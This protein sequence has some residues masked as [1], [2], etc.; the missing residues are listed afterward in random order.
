VVLKPAHDGEVIAVAAVAVTTT[1]AYRDWG[2]GKEKKLRKSKP[3]LSPNE[4]YNNPTVAR[5]L[6]RTCLSLK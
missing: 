4:P 3:K 5:E 1:R 6:E 2:G